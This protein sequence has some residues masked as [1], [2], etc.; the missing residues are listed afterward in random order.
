M[1]FCSSWAS[2][3]CLQFVWQTSEPQKWFQNICM[4]KQFHQGKEK[5]VT[6]MSILELGSPQHMIACLK[7]YSPIRNPRDT[8]HWLLQWRCN[9][10]PS[11]IDQEV[12]FQETVV[13][14]YPHNLMAFGVPG[15]LR[16][17]LHSMVHEPSACTSH[18]SCYDIYRITYM[19]WYW[20]H[21][22]SGGKVY[23]AVNI[24]C[25]YRH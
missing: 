21:S 23:N 5:E 10:I 6:G 20:R 7:Y 12:R 25:L 8:S 4:H 24:T 19:C 15:Q 11:C 13:G 9:S 18:S 3:S 17:I 22:F 2:A 16:T 1:T 14:Y